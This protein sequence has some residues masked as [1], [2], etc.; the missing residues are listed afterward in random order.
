[1]LKELDEALA[2]ELEDIEYSPISVV[3]FGYEQ[4]SHDLKGFWT[5]NNN[6]S[7]NK[8]ILGVLWDSSIFYDRA[9]SGKKSL[10]VMIGGK[11]NPHLALK[12]DEELIAIAKRRDT[13]D[14]GCERYTRCCLCKKI[15]KRYPKL[16]SRTQ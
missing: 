10:R 16:P 15:Y 9:P 12:S 11:R 8:K 1:M 6:F 7:S 3:G 4:F 5:L 2:K 13:R 14:Y